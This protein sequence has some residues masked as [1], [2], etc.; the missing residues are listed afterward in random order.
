MF[1]WRPN[2]VQLQQPRSVLR[3]CPK[4]D[5]KTSIADLDLRQKVRPY[6]LAND[7]FYVPPLLAF[8]MCGHRY[9]FS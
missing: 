7:C 2:S 8:R 1:P 4:L 5:K 6:L 9:A 3:R